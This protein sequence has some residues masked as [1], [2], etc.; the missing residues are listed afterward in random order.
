M[1]RQIEGNIATTFALALLPVVM[2]IGMAVDLAV[3]ETTKSRLKQA[4]D[5][6]A[7]AAL[8]EGT[9]TTKRID[10]AKSA[11]ASNLSGAIKDMSPTFTIELTGSSTSPVAT[12]GFKTSVPLAFGGLL[13]MR[14]I[15]ISG[16]AKAGMSSGADIDLDLWL[17]ASGSMAIAADEAGRDRLQSLFGCAFACHLEDDYTKAKNAGV[18]LRI[19]VMRTNVVKLIDTL[20]AGIAT[21]QV[22]RFRIS[23][24]ATGFTLRQAWTTSATTARSVVQ[25]FALGANK[26]QSDSHLSD[27]LVTGTAT[28]PTAGGD[29]YSSARHLVVFVTDGMQYKD[30][31]GPIDTTKCD[32]IKKRGITLAVVQLRYV[33]MTGDDK[34]DKRVKPYFNQL[35]PALEACASP[36]MFFSGETPSEIEQAFAGLAGK[37]R[38]KLRLME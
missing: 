6:A 15:E 37:M 28:L 2:A 31:P 12:T 19:D 1:L 17:D 23:A 34:F 14:S 20:S 35:K 11:F 38:G 24:I 27:G 18:T 25:N 5:T 13:G 32:A 30:D 16:T 3:V 4:I 10:V 22:V 36:E 33:D 26:A 29:G 9:T 7:L 21:G 8:A